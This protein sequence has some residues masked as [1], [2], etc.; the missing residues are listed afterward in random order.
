MS[1]EEVRPFQVDYQHPVIFIPEGNSVREKM[2]TVVS[3]IISQLD[4]NWYNLDS[5]D[6]MIF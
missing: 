5:I 4:K 3:D 1:K 2:S 6:I